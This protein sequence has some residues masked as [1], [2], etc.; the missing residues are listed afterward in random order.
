MEAFVWDQHFSTGLDRVDGAH[1]DLVRLINELGETLIH[2]DAGAPEALQAAFDRLADY[3]RHHFAD[4]EALMREGGVAARHR[5]THHQHHAGFVDQLSKIWSARAAMSRPAEAL[6][7]FLRSWLAF[8]ILGVDH[9]MARQMALIQAGKSPDEAYEIE[10]TRDDHA[11][12]A[13]LKAIGNLYKVLSQQNADLVAANLRLEERVA[14]RTSELA[15][16]NQALSELNLRLEALSNSDGLLGIANRRY[17]DQTL[18]SEWRRAMRLGQAVSLL[19]IDVDHFKLYNDCYGHQAGD[20]CLRAIAQAVRSPAA[21][22]RPGDLLARY[23]GEELVVLLPNT[24]RA[25]ALCTAQAIQRAIAA[26]Q[27]PHGGSPVA[28]EVTVSIGAA[29]QWP[30]RQ[31][32]PAALLTSADQ[33]LYAAKEAGRNRI[34]VA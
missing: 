5:A 23:G 17:F 13:L 1:H 32:A 15:R 12:T 19:M 27:L 3:A 14:E 29:T 11:T 26:L 24:E 30:V 22:K 9:S 4:E 18:D 8:H 16:A 10:L 31:S 6:H 20:R 2:G 33:A 7:G 34:S 21:L 25:G 28:A